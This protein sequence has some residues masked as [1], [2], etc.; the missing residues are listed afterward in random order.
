V[1]IKITNKMLSRNELMML[2]K[3]DA[4]LHGG[5]KYWP[6]WLRNSLAQIIESIQ[7]L[8]ITKD[9]PN[10]SV[11]QYLGGR[12]REPTTKC[13]DL[14]PNEKQVVRRLYLWFISR[15]D[16]LKKLSPEISNIS[17][18]TDEKPFSF[19]YAEDMFATASGGLVPSLDNE[20]ER[21]Y[22]ELDMSISY[23][24]LKGSDCPLTLLAPNES[25][26]NA[27]RSKIPIDFHALCTFKI[28]TIGRV[29]ADKLCVDGN[30]NRS[31]S[32]YFRDIYGVVSITVAHAIE[33]A[34]TME[35][36]LDPL[37]GIDVA[38]VRVDSSNINPI[39]YSHVLSFNEYAKKFHPPE[40]VKVYKMGAQTGLTVGV[41][42]TIER[43][44]F[45]NT[46]YHTLKM[47]I[48][49]LQI[50]YSYLTC[51]R[52]ETTSQNTSIPFAVP[53][54]SGSTV[55]GI[56]DGRFYPLGLHCGS[57]KPLS[58][59]VELHRCLGALDINIVD[60]NDRY[61]YNNPLSADFIPKYPNTIPLSSD[62]EN[63]DLAPILMDINVPAAAK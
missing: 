58:F 27:L 63:T 45:W 53:G 3:E 8:N 61:L 35:H 22:I 14:K 2:S 29:R 44:G 48:A 49:T 54:D 21:I 13:R 38:V 51:I 6:R 46:E 25:M 12:L 26:L 33:S 15:F 10:A 19:L 39:P 47:D 17:G 31:T 32:L 55:F 43:N 4:F 28:N 50:R 52:W 57:S 40:R 1:G 5:N 24:V 23:T 9:N 56:Y 59:A 18:N 11:L 16:K 30:E 37:S 62:D 34:R 41:L 20:L 42:E 60:A 36:I 7:D